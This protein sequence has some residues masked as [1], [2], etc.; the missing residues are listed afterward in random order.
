L[1]E[2]TPYHILEIPDGS[3]LKEIRKAYRRLVLKYHPDRHP[4]DAEAPKRFFEVQKA[5]ETLLKFD[6]SE[7][8]RKDAPRSEGFNW[9]YSDFYSDPFLAFYMAVNAQLGKGPKENDP[10]GGSR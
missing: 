8:T 4:G 3:D 6:Q 1:K 9:A 2:R 5:Y 7:E 10:K